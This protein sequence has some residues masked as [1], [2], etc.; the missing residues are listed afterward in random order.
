VNIILVI[1]IRINI[2]LPGIEV[3]RSIMK[4]LGYLSDPSNLGH[5]KAPA[6]FDGL[7]R[8]EM[9]T[10]LT[11]SN[12]LELEGAEHTVFLIVASCSILL[13][14]CTFLTTVWEPRLNQHPYSLVA[15]IAL[16]D[17]MFFMTFITLEHICTFR[18][19]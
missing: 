8:E 9:C 1:I 17:S 14:I 4:S 6:T 10:S 19:D 18:M 16:I 11:L 5:A 15:F 2:M 7:S 13:S 12:F 3:S